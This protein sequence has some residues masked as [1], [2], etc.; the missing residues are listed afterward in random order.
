MNKKQKIIDYK[1]KQVFEYF[2]N[3]T[4]PFTVLT[5]PLDILREEM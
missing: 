4:C 3:M 1:R 2:D 5:I